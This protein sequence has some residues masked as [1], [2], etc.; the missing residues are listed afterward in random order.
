[1][2][3]VYQISLLALSSQCFVLYGKQNYEFS[4]YMYFLNSSFA[5]R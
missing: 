1:M 2:N 5:T 4:M 3:F